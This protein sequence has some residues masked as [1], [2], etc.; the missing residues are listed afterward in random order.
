MVFAEK[1]SYHRHNLLTHRDKIVSENIFSCMQ[2][3]KQ[4][5]TKPALNEHLEKLHSSDSIKVWS[6]SV[7]LKLILANSLSQLK[8]EKDF[9][10][11]YKV[12]DMGDMVL[13]HF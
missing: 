7:S 8:D 3:D 12:W 6:E 11:F 13:R 2:C 9:Y 5:T 4:F 1:D 10:K